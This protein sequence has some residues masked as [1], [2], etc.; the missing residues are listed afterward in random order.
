MGSTRYSDQ[1]YSSWYNLFR[2]SCSCVWVRI[3]LKCSKISF[4]QPNFFIWDCSIRISLQPT[5]FFII[6]LPLQS[7]HFHK[8]YCIILTPHSFEIFGI[9]EDPKSHN[10]ACRTVQT[11]VFCNI[12]PEI[13]IGKTGFFHNNV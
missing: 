8:Q 13:Y 4:H 9:V 1:L 3:F 12:L 5:K 11:V 10:I 2:Y 7:E 6:F